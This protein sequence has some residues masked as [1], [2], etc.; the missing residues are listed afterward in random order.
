MNIEILA[1][2]IKNNIDD[3]SAQQI[4]NKFIEFAEKVLK[5]HLYSEREVKKREIEQHI[6]DGGKP[7]PILVAKIG[8]GNVENSKMGRYISDAGRVLDNIVPY[9]EYLTIVVPVRETDTSLEILSVEK[10]DKENQEEFLK[11][12]SNMEKAFTDIMKKVQ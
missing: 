7:R 9:N 11:R 3:F 5:E 6:K 1:K 12:L 8:I 2:N 10:I 4:Q